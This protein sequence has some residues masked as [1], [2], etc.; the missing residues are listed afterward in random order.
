MEE[1]EAAEEKSTVPDKQKSASNS[2]SR[3]VRSGRCQSAGMVFNKSQ[4]RRAWFGHGVWVGQGYAVPFQPKRPECLP[5]IFQSVSYQTLLYP[6]LRKNISLKLTTMSES[7]KS[8]PLSLASLGSQQSMTRFVWYGKHSPTRPI[9]AMTLPKPSRRW[10]W[11]TSSSKCGGQSWLTSSKRPEGRS[12]RPGPQY[13]RA[14]LPPAAVLPLQPPLQQRRHVR[15]GIVVTRDV[16]FL[17]ENNDKMTTFM[18]VCGRVG[19]HGRICGWKS[20]G[21]AP[22][23]G[24]W[25]HNRRRRCRRGRRERAHWLSHRRIAGA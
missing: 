3:P 13:S 18:C 24:P 6:R 4:S 14:P 1:R 2:A 22:R 15:L 23:V 20:C 21:P 19:A 11:N 8:P 25:P 17:C 16:A 12:R 5:R 7:W 10:R 9:T